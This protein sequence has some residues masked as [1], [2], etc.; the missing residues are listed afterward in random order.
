MRSSEPLGAGRGVAPRRLRSQRGGVLVLYTLMLL[1]VMLPL[2]GLAI[3]L[4]IVY[5]VKA[6]LST[7]VDGG[8]IAAARSLNAGD[9]FTS[10]KAS[11]TAAAIQFAKANFPE[12][13]WST[14]NLEVNADVQQN[15]SMMRSVTVTAK[16]KVPLIFLRILGSTDVALSAEGEATRRNVKVVFA[17]DR[18]SSLGP[19]FEDVKAGAEGFVRSFAETQDAVGLVVF[20]GSAVV[21]Y[22]PANDNF[23]TGR[24]TNIPALIRKTVSGSNTGMAEALTI[25]HKALQINPQPGAL[26]VIVLFTDGLPNGLT[27]EANSVKNGPYG[28]LK[29]SSPCKFKPKDGI[30]P[31]VPMIGWMAQWSTFHLTGTTI[32]LKAPMWA[33]N[34]S[35]SELDY[36]LAHPDEPTLPFQKSSDPACNCTFAG[37][38][39]KMKD[40]IDRFPDQ[41]YWGNYT[42]GSNYLLSKHYLKEHVELDK[43]GKGVDSP[44]QVG[45]RAWN[46]TDDAA[47]NIRADIALHPLVYCIG[48]D[49]T[50]TDPGA[51]SPDPV[52]MRRIA[53]EAGVADPSKPQGRYVWAYS[54]AELNAAMQSIASEILRLAR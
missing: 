53:N 9:D 54:T 15:G 44:Y 41:D 8:A 36:M 14:Q 39:S 52:L 42:N 51:E 4:T 22:P 27:V 20:G 40:D 17:M 45:L 3:D 12:G 5:I 21:A 46:A 7:A 19:V 26:N 23:L 10:Q 16:V 35:P 2:V 47:A 13:E 30:P 37:G 38:V 49:A 25:A 18:S 50:L 24:P 6:R 33:S 34:P 28:I 29:S 1:L 31:A 48:Y 32:G 43:N 11:A